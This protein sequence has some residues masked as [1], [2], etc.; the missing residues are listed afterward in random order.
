[1]MSRHRRVI[2]NDD[3]DH[4]ILFRPR[5]AKVDGSAKWRP[6]K[7]DCDPDA[8]LIDK[9]AKYE[10]GER[11]DDYRQRMLVNGLGFAWTVTLIAIAVWLMTVNVYEIKST[12]RMRFSQ[13]FC[14]TD[15]LSSGGNGGERTRRMPQWIG[16]PPMNSLG[17]RKLRSATS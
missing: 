4:V 13:N 11:E 7:R 5:R 15:D 14:G 1:M 12:P 6:L 16:G 3:H 17:T 8:L 10:R 2:S 9:L